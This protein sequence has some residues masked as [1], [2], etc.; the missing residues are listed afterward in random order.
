MDNDKLMSLTASL[1]DKYP[2]AGIRKIE[3]GE[4]NGRA[5]FYL[6]PN[7]V[8][9]AVL[10]KEAV[11]PHIGGRTETASTIRRTAID[12]SY[13]DLSVESSPYE[14]PPQNIFER[15]M[16]Y[17]YENDVYGVSV[18]VL[19]NF[20]S[21]GF[22]NDIDDQEIKL[23][24]D[25]WCF[26]V[27]FKQVLSWIFFDLIRIGMVRTYKIVGKYE[28][29]I[30]PFTPTKVKKGKTAKAIFG[31][32]ID[33]MEK[34]RI[35]KLKKYVEVEKE[36]EVG[37]EELPKEFAAKKKMWSKGY[38]P[39]A[40][41]VLNPLLV[42][43]EGSLLFNKSKT[44]LQPSN[45]LKQLFQKEQS[46]LTDDEKEMLKLLPNE[47]KKQI[48]EGGGITLDSLYV[49]EVDYRKQPYERYPRP[50]GIKAFTSLE[51]KRALREADLS[52][53]DGISNY[54]LKI[55]IGNDEYPVID[56]TQLET[57]AQL[58]NTPSKSFDVVWNHTL[59]IEKIVS[60]EIEA[61]LGKAKYEQVNMDIT[62]ALGMSRSFFDGN[63]SRN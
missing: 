43:I 39:T 53:L 58:F 17:Y 23:F 19:A 57:V 30:T 37:N 34:I 31:E 15:A 51:Y 16:K 11:T 25:T 33:R 42:E 5:V 35:H 29:G 28:P 26:D 3:V 50:R 44:V 63:S 49:G 54:I 7:S 45:E 24:F 18:D 1:Q 47:F 36:Y 48:E 52:T 60:P 12:R 4:G 40:Y 20:A 10:G 38:M 9:L 55:T 41:T 46:E 32:I 6:N 2:E 61:I 21:K 13:L 56:Q 8:N 59:K 27:G 22:E 14:Q 62:G